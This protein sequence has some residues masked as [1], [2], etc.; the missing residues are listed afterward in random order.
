MRSSSNRAAPSIAG[1]WPADTAEA[2]FLLDF[3]LLLGFLTT[4]L[5][6]VSAMRSPRVEF[7]SRR[8]FLEERPGRSW[9]KGPSSW[10]IMSYRRTPRHGSGGRLTEKPE[11]AL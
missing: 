11:E 7:V 8:P 6:G 10:L 2:L 3:T 5:L 9:D 4:L 1:E